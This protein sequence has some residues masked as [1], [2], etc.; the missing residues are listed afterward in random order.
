MTNSP[1]VTLLLPSAAAALFSSVQIAGAAY[2]DIIL[3]DNPV[4]YYRFEETSGTTAI[5]TANSND[6]TYVNGVLLDQPTPFFSLRLL[7][8]SVVTAAFA[9]PLFALLDR[10]RRSS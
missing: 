4:A 6:G 2:P 9:V 8:G 5:D 7:L 3:A 1:G 10:L